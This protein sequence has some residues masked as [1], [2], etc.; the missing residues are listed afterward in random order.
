MSEGSLP[1]FRS[2]WL[3]FIPTLLVWKPIKKLAGRLRGRKMEAALRPRVAD[4][5][6]V[7]AVDAHV[8][9]HAAL[10]D[11]AVRLREKADR[12]DSEGTPSESASNRADRAA[13]EA[14]FSLS[15]LRE[16]FA[17][18]NGGGRLRAFDEEV[19]RRY[20]ALHLQ[21]PGS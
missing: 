3:R 9:K 11:R 19:K 17:V 16:S 13:S 7:A 21:I 2:T 8:E 14:A 4:A 1:P 20:P 12:L 15:E 6:V 18:S 10:F 5:S